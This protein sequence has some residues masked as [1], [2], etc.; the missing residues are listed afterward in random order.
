MNSLIARDRSI[1]FIRYFASFLVV[2]LHVSAQKW[3]SWG[4]YNQQILNGL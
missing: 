3:S 4:D 2:T 1:D